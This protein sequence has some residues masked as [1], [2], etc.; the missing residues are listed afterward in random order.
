MATI[1]KNLQ[2]WDSK[3]HWERGV[4]GDGVGLSDGEK[5]SRNWGSSKNQWEV[6]I[7]PRIREFLPSGIMLELAPGR[8]RWTLFLKEYAQSL[9]IADISKLCIDY[10]KKRFSDSNNIRYLTNDGRTLQGVGDSEVDFIFSF[11]SLV[12]VDMVDIESYLGEFSR[13]LRPGGKA[14][15]HHSNLGFYNEKVASSTHMRAKDVSGDKVAKV[16]AQY[17]LQVQS[18]EFIPWSQDNA[19][20]GVYLDVMTLLVK[21][22][23]PID[24]EK[25]FNLEFLAE[26]EIA[27]SMK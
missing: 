23:Q 20:E 11:D 17:Q 13:V 8:G 19:E 3:E 18:Q 2:I 26:H 12:H 22:S 7:L 9:V 10:C 1:E 24:V 27:Q 15:I 21:S 16:A 4:Y 5:W 25:K 14:F 6:T